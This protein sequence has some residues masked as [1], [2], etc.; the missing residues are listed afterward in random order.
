MTRTPPSPPIVTLDE[1][2][3]AARRTLEGGAERSDLR[4]AILALG[5]AGEAGEVVDLVKKWIGHNK[6]RDISAIQKELGDVLW[7][8]AA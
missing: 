3:T 8:I 4:L 5:V 7:Y 6:S 2:Q 1:Y